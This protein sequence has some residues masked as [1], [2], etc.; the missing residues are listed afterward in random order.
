MVAD[1]HYTEANRSS[2]LTWDVA[3]LDS[4]L[5][6][7]RQMVPG[8]TMTYSGLKNDAQRADLIAYLSTLK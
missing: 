4:Y 6:A 1:F 7:P 2:G 3:T 5:Q 8:T